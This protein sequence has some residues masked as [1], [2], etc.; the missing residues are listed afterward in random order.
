MSTSIYYVVTFADGTS[1]HDERHYLRRNV[2]ADKLSGLIA[3]YQRRGQ[4][5]VRVEVQP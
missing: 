1:N 4:R 2:P 3:M 5:I